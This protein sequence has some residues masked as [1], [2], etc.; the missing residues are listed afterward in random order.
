MDPNKFIKYQPYQM[1]DSVKAG[2]LFSPQ[3]CEQL[4]KKILDLYDENKDGQL[5]LLDV[6]QMQQD[7]YRAMNKN[8]NPTPTDIA[9]FTRKMDT[10]GQGRVDEKNIN[11]LCM[12]YLSTMVS[13]SNSQIKIEKPLQ[14]I[15]V[16]IQPSDTSNQV[17][18]QLQSSRQEVITEKTQEAPKVEQNQ[19]LI[20]PKQE[21]KPIQPVQKPVLPEPT[22][23]VKN[24]EQPQQSNPEPKYTKMVQDRLK[25]AR[26]IFTQIDSDQSGFITETEVP[27]LLIETYKQMGMTIEPTK[28]DVELWMEMAD[29][30]KDGKVSLVD[31]ED[32]I[33]KGLQQQ[34][35][36]LE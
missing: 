26:R 30:D 20:K 21:E 5:D 10:N 25:V 11:S 8:Y 29:Q 23:T 36:K 13:S 34:G 7:C 3:Q 16:K 15:S 32:L 4:A 22:K 6:S 28:E 9:A 31:Y 12:K 1:T 27:S 17:E 33:I 2:G 35:I 18:I 19:I 14:E 24:T